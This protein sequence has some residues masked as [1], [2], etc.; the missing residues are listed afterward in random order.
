M[1]KTPV[2]DLTG[3]VFDRLSVVER[4]ARNENKGTAVW[5]CKCS[6]GN[7]TEARGS[8]LR[9]GRIRSCGCLLK[10]NPVTHGMSRSP[11]Y[12]IWQTMKDRCFR[13]RAKAYK[14]YGGRGIEVCVDWKNDFTAFYRYVGARPSSE[15]S[16]DRIDNN[17]N[18]EPG[19]VRWATR[20]QQNANRRVYVSVEA[21][22]TD[23]LIA[24]LRR[25][26]INVS[27]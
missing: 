12:G 16:L 9:A 3:M 24:E 13:P 17:G 8:L 25:R 23:Q 21:I 11:E 14:N 20:R 1:P 18:Y 27:G 15:F 26:G 5:V 6:C 22:P 4:A 2:K 19:N 10:T 7:R